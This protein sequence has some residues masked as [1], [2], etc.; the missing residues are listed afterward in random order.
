MLCFVEYSFLRPTGM[1]HKISSYKVGLYVYEHSNK[2]AIEQCEI[3]AFGWF[4]SDKVRAHAKS[5]ATSDMIEQIEAAI[6]AKLFAH[7]QQ[8]TSAPPTA[9]STAASA[10]K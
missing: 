4:T 5:K 1:Q 8:P 9:T 3:K 2:V 10:K 6:Q 7:L